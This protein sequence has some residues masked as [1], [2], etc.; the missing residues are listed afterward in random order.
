MNDYKYEDLSIGMKEFFKV[1]I[2]DSMMKSFLNITGDRN[3]LHCDKGYAELHGYKD[4]IVYGMLTASFLSTLAGEYLPGRR[5]LI[6]S[7]EIKFRKPVFVG[8]ILS[9]RGVV[10]MLNN[11]VKQIT[12]KVDITNQNH[13]KVVK[14]IMKIGVM[15]DE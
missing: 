15:N 11:T 13:V 10:D 5:S 12:L 8:D 14:G 3:P 7:V 2:T 6:H 4:N 9:V 1:K